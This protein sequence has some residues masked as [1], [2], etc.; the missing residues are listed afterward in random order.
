M[1][2]DRERFAQLQRMTRRPSTPGEL[3]ADLIECNNLTQG[4][5]AQS[6][7][8]SRLSVNQL[9]QGKRNVTP[10]MAQRLG[11]FFGNGPALW[12]NMQ[13]NVELWDLLHMDLRRYE[14]IQPLRDTALQGA[15]RG[16][17]RDAE[18]AAA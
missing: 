13:R 15:E 9:V 17:E 4:E 8:V 11:R 18:T 6:L 12:L 16:A 1:A 5:V 10:D 2:T 14:D 3:L 7:G